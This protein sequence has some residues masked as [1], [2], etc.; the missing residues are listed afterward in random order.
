MGEAEAQAEGKRL[1]RRR[2]PRSFGSN[3]NFQRNI[4]LDESLETDSD[5]QTQS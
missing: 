4:A 2:R 1:D 5:P 3:L